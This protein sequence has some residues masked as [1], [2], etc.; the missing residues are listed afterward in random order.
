[1]I[2]FMYDVDR[3]DFVG[4][5]YNVLCMFLIL[6]WDVVCYKSFVYQKLVFVYLNWVDM[7]V[8]LCFFFIVFEYVFRLKLYF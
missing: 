1:M 3:D 7:R 2:C 6:I 4:K 8:G 5:V